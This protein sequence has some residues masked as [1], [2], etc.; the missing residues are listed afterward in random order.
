ME[1]SAAVSRE[2]LKIPLPMKE[3]VGNEG[4]IRNVELE[5]NRHWPFNND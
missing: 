4:Q 1:A 2:G 5:E 3:E